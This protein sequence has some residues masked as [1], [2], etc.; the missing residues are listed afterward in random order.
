MT[1]SNEWQ[2]VR[3]QARIAALEAAL[4]RRSEELRRIQ[5]LLPRADLAVI[6]RV[7]AEMPLGDPR[8]HSASAWRETYQLVPG[9]VDRILDDLW[10]A[11]GGPRAERAP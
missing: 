8:A 2:L 9:E 3:L 5:Q 10:S 7:V 1:D 4:H 11:T 6:E